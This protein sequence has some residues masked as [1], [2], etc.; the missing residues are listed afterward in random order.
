MPISPYSAPIQYEYKPLNLSAFAA[1]LSEMQQKFDIVTEA[2]DAADF[3]LANLPYGTDPERAKE[4]IKIVKSKRDELAKNLGETKNYKQAASKLRELNNLWTKDPELN[5]LQANAQ[6]WAERDKAEL[7]RVGKGTD[8]GGITRDQ[9]LQWKDREIR[10][11]KEN[12]GAGFKASAADPTGTYNVITGSTGRLTD[13]AKDLEELS[14]KVAN[15]NPAQKWDAFRE[16]GIDPELMDKKFVKTIVEEK[17]ANKIAQVTSEYLK[18]LPRFKDWATEVADYNF[19][20]LEQN[21]ENYKA[22]ASDLNTKYLSSL[23][24][25]IN[26][27][28]KDSK[29]DKKIL[30]SAEY[31][32][33]LAEKVKAEKAS[34]TGE[35]D[36]TATKNLFTHQHLNDVYDMGALGK[37]LAYKNV[38]HDY[39]FRALPAEDTSG[40]PAPPAPPAHGEGFFIPSTEEKW[41]ITALNKQKI[42]SGKNLY[43]VVAKINNLVS[44]NVRGAIMGDPNSKQYKELIKHPDQI[45]AK[46]E[47]LLTT[48]TQTIQSGGDWQKFQ[49]AANKKGIVMSD[50]RARTLW[51]SLTKNGNQGI[52]DFAAHIK[53]SEEDFATYNQASALATSIKK[54]VQGTEEYKTFIS[55]LENYTPTEHDLG[56]LDED[57]ILLGVT[58]EQKRLF[59]PKSYSMEQLKKIGFVPTG[60]TRRIAEVLGGLDR[61]FL[62]LNDIAKLRGYK[63]VQDAVD[64][65]YNFAGFDLGAIAKESGKTGSSSIWWGTDNYSGKTVSEILSTKQ[66]AIYQK[67]NSKNEM[68]YNF[69]NDKNLDKE[70]S[71]YFLGVSDLSSYQPAYSKDWNGVPGFTEDGKLAPGTTLNISENRSPKIKV[72]GNTLL[73]EVPIKYDSDGN[74]SADTEGT[75]VIRPKAGMNVK[76]DDLLYKLD[77]ASGGNTA[78]EKQTNNMI[79]AARFDSKFQGNNL[80]PQLIQ[81]VETTPLNKGGKPIELYSIPYSSN[82]RLEVVKI[83]GEA[84]TNPVIKIAVVDANSGKKLQYVP[85]IE[86]GRDWYENADSNEAASSAK[87]YI[88]QILSTP[89]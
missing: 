61:K 4:L 18:T 27:L 60:T 64:K 31:K 3:T 57:K 67:N 28:E 71:R 47:Q 22:V 39:T 70:M 82:T 80:S 83:Q 53:S 78:L 40:A 68:S 6:L 19:D 41:S 44:G 48:L 25:Q 23:N 66:N 86:T 62:S 56:S 38:T 36:P 29:K 87:S 77:A 69:I 45:R 13:L 81:S 50:N 89:R 10:K 1:P 79:K 7:A 35:Y 16:A 88:M 63:N 58:E 76:N 17:D 33:L 42:D 65:G 37:V 74:G 26:K 75:V 30:E 21:P 85:N 12:K 73:Y 49:T 59:N 8:A 43:G 9:Y 72:H 54:N 15:A 24:Y 32:D 11:Y 20:A 2:V 51:G 34:T 55:N 46:Q 84:G 14:W 52:S 5:A